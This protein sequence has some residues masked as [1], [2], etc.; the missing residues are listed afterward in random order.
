MDIE[1]E[2]FQ[3]C[4]NLR[5]MVNE[6]ASG[7]FTPRP[8]PVIKLKNWARES[9][10]KL[11]REQALII[12]RKLKLNE[13]LSD[14]EARLTEEWMVGDLEL[15]RVM[16]GHYEEWKAEVL[17]LCT[18]LETCEHSGVN[19]DVKC[20]LNIQVVLIELE[21]VL[22]DMDNYSYAMDRIK[23]YRSYVGQNINAL[24]HDEKV[25]MADLMRSMVYSD[26][27]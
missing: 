10:Q 7:A 15:Y 19:T 6:L 14:K 17:N 8:L 9:Y 2:I 21:H 12:I 27:S 5:Q 3:L 23:R 13:S 24:A 26:L 22:R 1:G 4:S 11:F 25:K 18:R 20:L 16:E